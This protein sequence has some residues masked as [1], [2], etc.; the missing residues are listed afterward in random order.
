MRRFTTLFHDVDLCLVIFPCHG[1]LLNGRAVSVFL[2][3]L[4]M[5]N[6]NRANISL[7]FEA[8]T[9]G[10]KIELEFPY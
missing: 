4:R 5:K 9:N 7:F 1:H 10:A 3:F 6:V 2:S 8:R